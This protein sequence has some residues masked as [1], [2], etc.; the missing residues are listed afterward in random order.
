MNQNRTPHDA[1]DALLTD[2]RAAIDPG[3][4][5][6]DLRQRERASVDGAAMSPVLAEQLPLGLADVVITPRTVDEVPLVLSAAVRHGIPVTARGRGT[7]NYGQGI[8]LH[9]GI[10]LDTGRLSAVCPAGDGTITVE[11]G[12]RIRAIDLAARASGQELVLMPSTVQSSIGGF[13]AGG[14]GGAGTIEFGNTRQGF[15]VALDVVHAHEDARIEHVTGDAVL[16]YLHSFGVA[17]VIVRATVRLRPEVDWHPLY[18][19]FDR[20]ADAAA[21]FRLLGAL[22]PPPRLVSADDAEIAAALP[23]DEAV[24]PA[25]ASLRAVLAPGTVAD[26]RAIVEAHGGRVEDVRRGYAETMKMS[27]TAYN[28]PAWWFLRAHAG[29]HFHLEVFGD[30]LLEDPDAVRALFG[31]ALLHLELGHSVNFGMLMLPYRHPDDVA[32]AITRLAE[33]GIGAHDCHSWMLAGADARLHAA[34]R[35]GDPYGLLNPGKLPAPVVA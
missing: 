28:H 17:G 4:I 29:E 16:P 7:G 22:T 31:D 34:A 30:A 11:A 15:V 24:D 8:P 3:G 14:S 26:A 18:A 25:R 35:H 23:R 1:L 10:V 19:S 32:T 27:M 9:G 21:T 6:L 33:A 13:L 2:L 20:L 5:A 12:A